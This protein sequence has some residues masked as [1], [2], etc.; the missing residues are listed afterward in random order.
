SLSIW[1]F[2]LYSLLGKELNQVLHIRLSLAGVTLWQRIFACM[3]IAL[4]GS[5]VSGSILF[6]IANQ[7]VHYDLYLID[8]L[9]FALFTVLYTWLLVVGIAVLDIWVT[10]QKLALLLQNLWTFILIFTSGAVIPTIYFPLAVQ[11]L[12]P[13]IF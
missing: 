4:V 2:A 5:V 11:Q 6:F 7:F 9:R 12:V 3:L 1:V 8:Y 13:Y 10:S